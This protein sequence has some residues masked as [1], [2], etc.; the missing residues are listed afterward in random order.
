M[1]F[2]FSIF[3]NQSKKSTIDSTVFN[4]SIEISDTFKSQNFNHIITAYQGFYG[5]SANSLRIK[6]GDISSIEQRIKLKSDNDVL[7]IVYDERIYREGN[8]LRM[9]V[10]IVN[11]YFYNKIRT[12]FKKM[13]SE[14]IRRNSK[15]GKMLLHYKEDI[16]VKCEK[17]LTHLAS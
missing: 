7:E 14:N 1:T 9:N 8:K 13:K 10:E 11:L 4:K 15:R 16:K 3:G 2:L 17:L 6:M 5:N 12:K